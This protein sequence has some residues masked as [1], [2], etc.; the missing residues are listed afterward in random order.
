[1]FLDREVMTICNGSKRIMFVSG[2]LGLLQ[3]VLE[4]GTERRASEDTEAQEGWIVRSYIG[5]RV[6]E[7]FI[8]GWKL[9]P[10]KHVLK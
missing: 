4:L 9:L 1:M 2:G 8:K 5:W 10:N 6:N 3:M 7:I